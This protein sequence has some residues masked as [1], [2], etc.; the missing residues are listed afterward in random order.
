VSIAA[1]LESV[2][3]LYGIS[4]PDIMHE[5][6]ARLL[7]ECIEFSSFEEDLNYSSRRLLQVWPTRF[8]TL[9][10]AQP[11][12]MQ[13]KKLAMKVYGCR[14]DLG[15]ITPEDGWIFR[16]SGPIQMTGR[17]N[18]ESFGSWMKKKFGEDKTPEQWA[19]LLRTSDHYGIH[20]A[21]WLFAVAKN[22]IGYALTDQLEAIVKKINGGVNGLNETRKYYDKCRMLIK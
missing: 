9:A 10:D 20:S 3:P 16:G 8:K 19:E 21:C 1:S 4:S 17:G 22:L 13:P 11:Y 6:L 15:N 7:E 12:A 5:F 14:E 2:C 18:I